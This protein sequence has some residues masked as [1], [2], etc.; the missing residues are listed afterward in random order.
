MSKQ[1]DH[2]NHIDYSS[3]GIAVDSCGFEESEIQMLELVRYFCMSFA[4]PNSYGWETAMDRAEQTFGEEAGARIACGIARLLRSVRDSRSSTFEFTNASCKA[5]S[6]R[7][8]PAELN[9]MRL[10]RGARTGDRA[11]LETAALIL[12]EGNPAHTLLDTA[13]S[14]ARVLNDVLSVPHVAPERQRE[15][16][17]RMH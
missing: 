1:H 11:Q 2:R 15:L 5:C 13:R 10:I 17:G 4:E 9:V 12:A 14:V 8:R 3:A 6:K 16:L 7:I